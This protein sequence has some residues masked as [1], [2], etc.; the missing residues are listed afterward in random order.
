[1]VY[2]VLCALE[3]NYIIR[4]VLVL[5]CIMYVPVV[6]FSIQGRSKKGGEAD[7]HNPTFDYGGDDDL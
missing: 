5:H 1:M 6:T 3:A 4:Q 7:V 2:I